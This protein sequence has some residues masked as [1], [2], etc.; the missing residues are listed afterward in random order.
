MAAYGATLPLVHE[1]A[2]GR[3]FMPSA[4]IAP[5]WLLGN[6]LSDSSHARLR[7]S[8]RFSNPEHGRVVRFRR[9]AEAKLSTHIQHRLV[10]VQH[11]PDQFTDAGLLCGLDQSSHKQ[12]PN[13]TPMP[14]ATHCNSKLCAPPI[15]TGGKA[16]D[17]ERHIVVLCHQCHLATIVQMRQAG[18]E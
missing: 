5:R 10:L 15:W 7:R 13:A 8:Q 12:V 18:C 2:K 11:Q 6:G 14:V 3:L 17:A 9:N 16:R 1:P 4:V